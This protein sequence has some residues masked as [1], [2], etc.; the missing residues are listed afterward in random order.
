V[1]DSANRFPK[2]EADNGEF[3]RMVIKAIGS[4]EIESDVAFCKELLTGSEVKESV[5]NVKANDVP[6]EKFQEGNK[7]LIGGVA[8]SRVG[9]QKLFKLTPI[10]PWKRRK[11]ATIG[12]L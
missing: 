2:L 4:F 1:T 3:S 11:R 12:R 10:K 6:S 7:K 8:S 9:L 5:A